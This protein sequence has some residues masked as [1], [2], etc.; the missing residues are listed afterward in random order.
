MTVAK[1]A[2]HISSS[3]QLRFLKE[4]GECPQQGSALSQ[5][6][7]PFGTNPISVN[8]LICSRDPSLGE[9]GEDNQE[10]ITGTGKIFNHAGRFT[11]LS[12]PDFMKKPSSSVCNLPNSQFNASLFKD[13]EQYHRRLVFLKLILTQFQFPVSISPNRDLKVDFTSTGAE[14][15]KRF[16]NYN[17]L[18]VRQD[19]LLADIPTKE[20]IQAW[21]FAKTIEKCVRLPAYVSTGRERGNVLSATFI[22]SQR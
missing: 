7:R 16:Y 11:L 12:F 19:P 9:F 21:P 2:L 3:G 15:I 22:A 4:V 5:R 20:V 17:A 10:A 14:G 6:Y 1:R 13:F 18:L 8:V